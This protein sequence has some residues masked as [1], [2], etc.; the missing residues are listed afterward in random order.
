MWM[1]PG[2]LDRMAGEPLEAGVAREASEPTECRY[3][4]SPLGFEGP[5]LGC[6]RQPTIACP[7]GHGTMQAGLVTVH[8]S[9]F[10][11]DRCAACGGLWVDSHERKYVDGEE[12]RNAR[13]DRFLQNTGPLGAV[14]GSAPS[15]DHLID[16]L[17]RNNAF[18]IEPMFNPLVSRPGRS[19][20]GGVI[21]LAIVALALAAGAYYFVAPMLGQL[22]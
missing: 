22:W 18:D 8:G 14:Q 19:E 15:S 9:E 20:P 1:A 11:I 13:V 12:A 2:A 7:R 10:E 4:Q 3:C 17:K 21:I 6:G 16:V 5:C